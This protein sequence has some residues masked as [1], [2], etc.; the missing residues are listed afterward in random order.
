MQCVVLLGPISSQF[1]M[2]ALVH[3]QDKKQKREWMLLRGFSKRKKDT[4]FSIHGQ[5]ML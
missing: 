4:I 3:V 1:M 5:K 2:E